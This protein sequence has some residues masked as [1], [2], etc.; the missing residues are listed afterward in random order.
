MNKRFIYYLV[1]LKKLNKIMNE[2]IK[3]ELN[4]NIAGKC[5]KKPSI[6]VLSCKLPNNLLYE[7]AWKITCERKNVD[8]YVLIRINLKG[9]N[10]KIIYVTKGIWAYFEQ[11][12]QQGVIRP[13][14]LKVYQI[15]DYNTNQKKWMRACVKDINIEDNW[16]AKNIEV[17]DYEGYKIKYCPREAIYRIYLPGA[18]E[19]DL[20]RS[21]RSAKFIM[22]AYYFAKA[23]KEV[24]QY[25]KEEKKKLRRV[26]N[27]Q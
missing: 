10:G 13:E 1:E 7:Y 23:K 21:W 2:G 6:V 3:G 18:T 20:S 15:L 16:R 22:C 5:Y 11:I 19:N 8:D 9:V 25:I 4:L 27:N 26:S 17:V 12:I 24:D 14:Y